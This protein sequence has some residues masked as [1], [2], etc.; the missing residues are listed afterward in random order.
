MKSRLITVIGPTAS[1]KTG[2]GIELAKKLGGAV[3]SADSRQLY[4]GMDIGTAKPKEAW[5]EG[6]HDVLVPN[7]IDGVDHYGFNIGA[8][9]NRLTLSKWQEVAF[10]MIDN[11]I[12]KDLTPL[13]VGGTMLYVDSVVKNYD[14]PDVGSQDELRE[15]LE[16]ESVEVLF[17]RLIKKD[18][19]AK[20]FIE[21]HHKQRIIRALEVMEVTGKLFSEQRKMRPAK[22]DVKMIGLFSSWD[23]L[24]KKVVWRVQE[25]LDDGLIEETVKLQQKYGV[26]LPLLKTMDYLQAGK[27]IAGEITE[28]EAVEEMVRVNMRYAHRQMSWWRG[29]DEIQWFNPMEVDL[30]EVVGVV[31]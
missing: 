29:R 26:D 24:E 22:Y 25:M 27:V 10:K 23:D 11:V 30:E 7:V 3:V 21:A 17:E 28:K 12:D 20:E 5:Q 19:A 15:E 6:V 2:V 13:L 18:P 31:S 16:K 14:I 1:G 9:D 4:A 8:P